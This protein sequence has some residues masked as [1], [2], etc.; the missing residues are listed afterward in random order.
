MNLKV[1]ALRQSIK[2]IKVLMTLH[3][4]TEYTSL[5]AHVG[6][7]LSELGKLVYARILAKAKENMTL[8]ETTFTSRDITTE[9]QET[10]RNWFFKTACVRELL[11]RM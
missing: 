5:F 2:A 4:I 7:L 6:S 11:P 9:A 3:T 8:H 10:C 1:A